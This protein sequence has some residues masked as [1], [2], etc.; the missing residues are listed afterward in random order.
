MLWRFVCTFGTAHLSRAHHAAMRRDRLGPVRHGRGVEH[1][2]GLLSCRRCLL[3]LAVHFR[4]AIDLGEVAPRRFGWRWRV[5]ERSKWTWRRTEVARRR[6]E[7]HRAAWSRPAAPAHL[8]DCKRCISRARQQPSD[9]DVLTA[10]LVSSA[11]L[12]ATPK[13][14][15]IRGCR[16]ADTA[17]E[18]GRRM[19]V[20]RASSGRRRLQTLRRSGKTRSVECRRRS[21]GTL[22]DERVA[23]LQ[24]VSAR[25]E[26]VEHAQ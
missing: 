13:V 1:R 25:G 14:P 10:C 23:T 19:L 9:R 15:S 12:L 11:E 22:A 4:V 5:L 2:R 26:H 24:T 6:R 3:L 8:E 21:A 16:S 17:R 18:V 7:R 20:E